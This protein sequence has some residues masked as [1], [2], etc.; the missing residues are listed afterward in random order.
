MA[1]TGVDPSSYYSVREHL[2]KGG[3]TGYRG[4]ADECLQGI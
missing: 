3:R 4:G 1:I 2:G